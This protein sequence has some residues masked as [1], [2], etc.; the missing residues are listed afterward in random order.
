MS[1]P[2]STE[3]ML[4]RLLDYWAMVYR[5]CWRGSIASS[6]LTPLLYVVSMGVLLGGFVAGDPSKLE[7]AHSYLAFVAPGLIAS[8]TM[9][10]VFG[11]VTWPVQSAIK[12]DRTYFSM[13]A[14]PLSVRDIAWGH[15]GFAVFRVT[16]VATVFVIVLIPFGVFTSAWG[17]IGA[18]VVQPLLGLAFAAPVYAI[19]AWASSEAVMT[20][21]F[22]L[23]MLPLFLFSGAFF[24]IENLGSV[25]EWVARITPLWQG[26][27]LTR[28]VALGH[29][30]ASRAVIH[31]VYLIVLAAIGLRYAVR[32]LEM[33][34]VS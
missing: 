20:M 16:L 23:V 26:V 24:P 27:D 31:V 11:E 1:T 3:P 12:W 25:L 17:L 4:L 13:T 29:V 22:R 32:A 34:L 7:G 21:M 5:R 19:S 33:R 14:T 18:L 9:T 10:T 15:L 28:M 2:V 6:F 30:D 8:Q